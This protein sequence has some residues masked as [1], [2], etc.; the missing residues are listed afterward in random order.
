MAP[1]WYRELHS[2]GCGILIK[3]KKR[4]YC[5]KSR[6]Q[7]I[8]VF[9]TEDFGKM[10]VLDHTIMLTECDEA[11]YHEMLTHVSLVSHPR[12]R[13]VLVI[14]GGDGGVVREILKHPDVQSI[15]LVEIDKQVL[16]VSRRFFPN[17]SAGFA[18]PKVRVI[19]ADGALH[20]RGAKK[21]T[22]DV[23]IIDST[24]P[25]GKGKALFNLPFYRQARR[26]MAPLGILTAQVGSPFF[27][28]GHV[29]ATF[30]K[31]RSVFPVALAYMVHVPTYSDGSYCLAFC[32]VQQ[33]PIA[34]FR[35][36]RV[37]H[38]QLKTR[39]YNPN[40]HLGAF[41]LPRFVSNLT[42]GRSQAHTSRTAVQHGS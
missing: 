16:D 5:H 18:S 7:T 38:L 31:L 25:V 17:I 21:A 6:Y 14:G 12:P 41:L 13:N 24:D 28:P 33:N 20:V 9:D 36:D 4:L 30:Q 32:S 10:L 26:A 22:Y 8:E 29:R 39:Y 15:D 1:T 37:S 2:P 19:I 35:S 40:V 34:A 11:A 23:I 42:T 27:T 3:A